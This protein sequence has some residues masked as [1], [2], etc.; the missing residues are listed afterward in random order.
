MKKKKKKKKK[1]S[2]GATVIYL[3]MNVVKRLSKIKVCLHTL[4]MCTVF[5]Y[6][7]Y[8]NTH[9]YSIYFE[10]IYMYIFKLY[11]YI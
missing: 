11:K 3:K 7:A 2:G 4:C 10:N 8:I 5:I 9:T 1:K 6:Y